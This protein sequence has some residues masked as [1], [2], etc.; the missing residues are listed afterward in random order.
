MGYN[1]NVL[2]LWSGRK[3]LIDCSTKC[4]IGARANHRSSRWRS[5]RAK[6]YNLLN[7]AL[8]LHLP[9]KWQS[10]WLKWSNS[11]IITWN[12]HFIFLIWQFLSN[13]QKFFLESI[14]R[15]INEVMAAVDTFFCG[16]SER[17][18][19][20][21]GTEVLKKCWNNC[22]DV[23][24]KYVNTCWMYRKISKWNRRSSVEN[25]L[26]VYVI[27]WMITEFTPVLF[28]N[29]CNHLRQIVIMKNIDERNDVM[30]IDPSYL[31]R[32]IRHFL[33]ECLEM[34]KGVEL[35]I[36][37]GVYSFTCDNL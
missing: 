31:E 35:I 13:F 34:R 29:L 25:F 1:Y 36:I 23:S 8:T 15:Q 12:L 14:S 22:M 21:N 30:D 28:P 11:F 10:R 9:T 6:E 37:F 33:N 3:H 27:A 7:I 24:K 17:P 26:F 18:F 20:K 2:L 5:M 4:Q 19:L 16:T 32:T